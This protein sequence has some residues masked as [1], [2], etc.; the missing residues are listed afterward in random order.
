MGFDVAR[1]AS[2]A[3]ASRLPFLDRLVSYLYFADLVVLEQSTC[4]EFGR[5]VTVVGRKGPERPGDGVVLAAPLPRAESLLGLATGSADVTRAG[6]LLAMAWAVASLDEDRLARPVTLVAARPDPLGSGLR[7]VLDVPAGRDCTVIASAPTGPDATAPMCAVAVLSLAMPAPV[8]PLRAPLKDVVTLTLDRCDAVP[9][10]AALA[11]AARSR[12]L[13]PLSIHPTSGVHM[14]PIE[15]LHISVGLP[16]ADFL[17]PGG[18]RVEE[19]PVTV[20]SAG[21][22]LDRVTALDAAL[23]TCGA[24]ALEAWD[25]AGTTMPDEPVRL[26]DLGS[27]DPSGALVA[28]ALPRVDGTHAFLEGLARRLSSLPDLH[29]SVLHAFVPG[30]SDGPASRTPAFLD[31]ASCLVGHGAHLVA[32]GPGPGALADDP[33]ARIRQ[34]AERYLDVLRAA[35]STPASRRS[36]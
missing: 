6:T 17:P 4:D 8:R 5:G 35:L 12:S 2:E 22:C 9:A 3:L 14:G 31:T 24:E 18:W 15:E 34:W 25:R 32:L 20:H 21:S 7:S 13:E 29:A 11:A 27:A 33:P 30:P 1:A 16:R 23:A 26:L 36:R 10:L 28:L 19:R